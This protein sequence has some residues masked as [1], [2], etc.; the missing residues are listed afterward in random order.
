MPSASRVQQ[1]TNR[2]Y[3]VKFTCPQ[4]TRVPAKFSVQGT[5]GSRRA[6]DSSVIGKVL[7]WLLSLFGKLLDRNRGLYVV[8]KVTYT[9]THSASVSHCMR[10]TL[11]G[12]NWCCQFDLSGDLPGTGTS[13]GLRAAL[14]N[15][16]GALLSGPVSIQVGYNS[17]ASD[18]CSCSGGFTPF[19]CP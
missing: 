13:I 4:E 10:C 14:Y 3:Y 12:V 6:P 9:N 17:T 18:P 1:E 15:S 2:S 11:S 5:A 7:S 19:P 16:T 8:C